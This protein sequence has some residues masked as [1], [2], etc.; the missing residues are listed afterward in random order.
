MNVLKNTKK[1]KKFILILVL[2]ILFNFCFPKSVHALWLDDIVAAPAF[3]FYELEKGVLKFLNNIF[4]NE[5]YQANTEDGIVENA[6]G[7]GGDIETEKLTVY[8][9]PETIIKGKFIIFDANIF[10]EITNDHNYYD[11]VEGGDV[12]TGKIKLREVVS[13]WYYALRNFAIVA[14]LSVLVYVAI[15]MIT[16]TIA[17]DKA[18]YKSMFKD[19]IVALCLLVFMHFIMIGILNVSG[20]IVEA[21]GGGGNSIKHIQYCTERLSGILSEHYD[22]KGTT[23]DSYSMDIDGEHLTIGDAYAYVIVLAG[24]I[25]FTILFAIKYLKREMTIIFLILLGP[26][27]CITYPIDKI[28]DGKAQAYNKWFSEFLFQVIIQPFHLLIYIVLVGS[29]MQLAETNVLYS[30]V[31]FAVMIPA[32]KFVKEMFGFR[33]RLGSPLGAFAGGALAGQLMRSIFSGGNK[34]SNNSGSNKNN[35]EDTQLSPNTKLLKLPGTKE[36]STES[37]TNPGNNNGSESQNSENTQETDEGVNTD[38]LEGSDNSQLTDAEDNDNN[39]EGTNNTSE[40]DEGTDTDQLGNGEGTDNTAGTDEGTDTDQLGNNED[41]DNIDETNEGES[42]N[43]NNSGENEQQKQKKPTRWRMARDAIKT[44]RAVN[45]MNKYGNNKFGGGIKQ[46]AKRA[47]KKA[48]SF[49]KGATKKTI[50]GATTIA[51]ATALGA[52]GVMFGQGSKFA[53][54]GAA[55]GNKAGQG[56]NNLANKGVSKVEN[57]VKAG[58]DGFWNNAEAKDKSEFMKN[59]RNVLL[60][61]QNYRDR[62]EGKEANGS[63]LE[64]E[65]E[66]MYN[67]HSH[68]V[69]EDQYNKTLAQSEDL[70]KDGLNEADAL[71]T[72]MFS[73]IQSQTISTKD[74]RDPKAMQNAYD[75]LARRYKN[76]GCNDQNVID[77]NVRRILTGAAKMKGVEMPALPPENKTIDIPIPI[78]QK[79]PDLMGINNE[80]AT[81]E[82]MERVNNITLRLQRAGYTDAQIAQVANSLDGSRMTIDGV[83]E[84]YAVNVEYLEDRT[85][86]DQAAQTISRINNGAKATNEQIKVEMLKRNEIRSE[87]NLSDIDITEIR[88]DESNLKSTKSIEVARDIA[89]KQNYYSEKQKE[90]EYKNL[91]DSLKQ[92]GFSEIAIENEIKNVQDLSILYNS[93]INKTS[94]SIPE[95]TTQRRTAV[96]KPETVQRRTAMQKPETVQRRTAMQKPETVQRRTAMQKPETAQR[97]TTAQ[98]PKTTTKRAN[99]TQKENP[100]PKK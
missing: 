91:K 89:K 49:A 23:N 87:F 71:D 82:Q 50:K 42:E 40:L 5:D 35:E 100:K 41:T 9:T 26:I 69:N 97:G 58:H 34:G 48:Y 37:N 30:L 32:E 27:S 53:M 60:A 45:R 20:K 77:E 8:L 33:D 81:K 22:E 24:I 55:I 38:N 67:M 39:V 29:A 73:A 19:W 66:N 21:L 92:E 79:V 63:Q 70:Q 86:Q 44:R 11:Y 83:I 28:T 72:A 4:A 47:G 96:Q 75:E 16:S 15:R 43:N 25:G 84:K 51:G 90:E 36:N 95:T 17:Q 18:K 78:E 57:Y 54:A 59:K 7:D 80:N 3:I 93:N 99:R 74:F 94:T 88:E 68:G 12:S 14:L 65:M 6:D 52:V 85:A 46:I 64:K 1:F 13:G 56:I 76:A 31:C 62:H 61:R 10:K 2:L 98:K